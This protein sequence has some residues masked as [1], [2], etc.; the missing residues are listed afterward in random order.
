VL[1]ER[2][3]WLG[4]LLV[5]LVLLTVV[6]GFAFY[7]P[8][9]ASPAMIGEE[10]TTTP[11]DPPPPAVVEPL[12]GKRQTFL[13]MGVDIIDNEVG[14]T[15]SMVVVSFD[16]KEQRL[17]M[18][19]IPRDTWALIPGH[20]YDKINHA[21]A[22]GGH[23]LTIDTVERLLGI[24]ID[25][26]VTVSFD[27][28]KQVIDALGGVEIDV[29][30]RLYY[31]DP[32]DWRSGEDGL[33][34]DIQPGLQ[35]MDGETALGYARFRADAE[36]DIGRMRRQQQVIRALMKKAATP[37]MLTRV[38]QL[39]PA[40]AST[41]GTDLS[42]AE[43]VR[44]ATG[45]RAA[46]GNPLVTGSLGGDGRLIDG[47]FYLVSDLV[48]SRRVAYEVLVGTPPDSAFLEQAAEDQA[49]YRSALDSAIA[50]AEEVADQADAEAEP[51]STGEGGAEGGEGES[52]GEGEAPAADPKGEAEQEQ[53]E[54][55]TVAVID[56][57]GK[58][59]G[60][61]YAKLLRALGFRVASIVRSPKVVDQSLVFDH[62][63]LQAEA[64]PRLTGII[65][66]LI[67]VPE[68]NPRADQALEILLGTDILE[69]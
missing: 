51:A 30:K 59:I 5:G 40:L 2:R 31:E 32:V 12:P 45:G 38:P 24:D 52:E 64:E 18:L 41:V 33:L 27:G 25:H 37:A 19:S 21:Y 10:D 49:T 46:L 20:G 50:Q 44:L 48:E 58:G 47:V 68:P 15:D 7:R 67:W 23:T 53:V 8:F 4:W 62:A 36:G 28:F 22:Y 14:R 66:T 13:V 42:V 54:P 6:G 26:Y 35:S 69:Q 16:P 11:T 60:R 61:D 17:A 29:E 9:Q 1:A 34:I 56:A 55:I 57:T 43:M 65:P 63:D 39:I 3:T